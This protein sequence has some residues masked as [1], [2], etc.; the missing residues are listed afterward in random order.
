MHRS[1]VD[2]LSEEQRGNQKLSSKSRV[3]R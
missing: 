3:S 2:I 1:L